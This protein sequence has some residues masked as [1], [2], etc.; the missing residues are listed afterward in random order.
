MNKPRVFTAIIGT[1]LLLLSLSAVAE[2]SV[3]QFDNEAQRSQFEQLTHELRCPKCQ[4]QSIADSDAQLAGDL[5][6]RVYKMVKQGADEQTIRQYMIDRYGYF[7]IYQPPVKPL[8]WILWFGPFVILLLALFC[9]VGWQRH[10]VRTT[11][12]QVDHEQLERVLKEQDSR[13]HS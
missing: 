5:R 6:Q 1:C 3:Y 9:Y 7:I 12:S 2:I 11:P 10:R 13:G 4:N 8:T